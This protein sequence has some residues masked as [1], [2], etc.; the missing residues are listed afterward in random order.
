ME[1]ER[2]GVG[3]VAEVCGVLQSCEVCCGGEGALQRCGGGG[4]AGGVEGAVEVRSRAAHNQNFP[5][6]VCIICSII[7]YVW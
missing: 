7:L 5:L 4:A 1:G 6:A 2:E 3:D